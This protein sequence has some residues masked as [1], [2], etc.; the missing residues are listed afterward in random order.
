LIERSPD[1]I[2]FACLEGMARY[3][4]PAGLRLVGLKRLTDVQSLTVFDF[5]ADEDRP[6]LRDEILPAIIKQGR[7]AGEYRL[8]HFVSGALVPVLMDCFRIDDPQSGQPISIATVSRD[9]TDQKRSETRL[10]K[11]NE[12]WERRIARRTAELERANQ[13]LA[14][15]IVLRGRSDV[16]LHRLRQ[17]LDRS[18][19]HS[20]VHQIGAAMANELNQPLAALTNFV[21]AARRMLASGGPEVAG[22]VREVMDEAVEQSLRAGKIIRRLREVVGYTGTAQSAED[23]HKIIEDACSL[24]LSDADRL[25]V[26]LHFRLAP[27]MPP[28]I[29]DCVQIQQVLVNL[30]RNAVEAMTGNRSDITVSTVLCGKNTV[31]V[32]IGDSG[33]GL[34]SALNGRLFEPFASTRRDRIGLG[35]SICRSVVEAHDG[36]IWSEP[37]P[38]GGTVFRFTLRTAQGN[39]TNDPCRWHSPHSGR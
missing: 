4:N 25:G 12:A 24:A 13:Q 19:Q 15:D 23:L 38:G 21:S 10:R 30:L 34:S 26:L 33:C 8:R 29:A 14:G 6:Q 18:V 3:V 32:A 20:T 27:H 39:E 37:N 31:Q 36:S 35:L 28:V 17:E 16:V 22:T 9:L 1:F 7:W 2:G 5:V 11:L